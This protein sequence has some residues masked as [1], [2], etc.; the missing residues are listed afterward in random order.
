MIDLNAGEELGSETESWVQG[1]EALKEGMERKGKIEE[2]KKQCIILIQIERVA[3]T[4]TSALAIS[5]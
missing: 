1:M 5:S 4:D 3:A 2:Q